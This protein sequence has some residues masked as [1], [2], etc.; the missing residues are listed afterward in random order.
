MGSTFLGGKNTLGLQKLENNGGVL[1][2]FC[3][4]NTVNHETKDLLL[5]FFELYILNIY[6]Y[7]VLC[8]YFCINVIS[9]LFYP[10][11]PS[12]VTLL[13]T[14]MASFS[15]IIGMNHQYIQNGDANM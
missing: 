13:F 15:D 14:S 3:N 11:N 9:C 6:Q 4:F 10:N 2:N 7:N 5:H 1:F 8:Q 12:F